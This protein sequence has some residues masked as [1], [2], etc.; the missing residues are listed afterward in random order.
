M[1]AQTVLF[2]HQCRIRF[3]DRATVVGNNAGTPL[4]HPCGLSCGLPAADTRLI[5][6]TT[7]TFQTLE[8]LF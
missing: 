8:W 3:G 7:F 5:F 4:T 1:G 6:P 2:G